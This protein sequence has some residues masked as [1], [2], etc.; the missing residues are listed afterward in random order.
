MTVALPPVV[1]TS[2]FAAKVPCKNCPFKAVTCVKPEGHAAFKVI[3]MMPE[4]V[5]ANPALVI[6]ESDTNPCC[7]T[8]A[9]TAH[10]KLKAKNCKALVDNLIFKTD[11]VDGDRG[12][13]DGETDA[14]RF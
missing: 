11:S 3:T 2:P 9:E 5:G 12:H 8:D 10:K 13:I 6:H 4:G 14:G 1:P 7:C